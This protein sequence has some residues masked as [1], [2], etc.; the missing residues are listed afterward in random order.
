MSLTKPIIISGAGISG[1][2]FAQGLL[3]HK[4]PFKIF[5]RDPA[6]NVRSQGYRV[7]INGYGVNALRAVL[8]PPLFHRLQESCPAT[9]LGPPPKINAVTGQKIELQ[10]GGKPMG[11]G[12]DA[13]GAERLKADR[14]V[15]RSVLMIGLE[16]FIEYGKDFQSYEVTENGVLVRFADGT[17]VEGSL[18]VGADGTKSGVRRQ[19][20]P[21]HNL[22]DTEGR[23]FYGKTFLTPELLETFNE[24]AAKS[25]A[26]VQEILPNGLP[27]SL[28]LE[29]VK[30]KDNEFRKDL[31]ADYVYWVLGSRKDTIDLDDVAIK[32]LTAEEA[33][34]ETLRLTAHWDPS[35]RILFELQEKSQTSILKI[36]TAKPEIP[37]WQTSERV[38]L[39]GDSV[40]AMS[41]TA[42]V[43]AVTALRSAASLAE[44]IGEKGVTKDALRE[45]ED[46]MRKVAGEAITRSQFGGKMI[47]G[48]RSFAELEKSSL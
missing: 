43:G 26:L 10:F 17:S 7:A 8:P 39:I 14:T 34:L 32:S 36:D 24:D 18:L 22:I 46:K 9:T 30:F 4:I 45:Y 27:R 11:P 42:G 20:L 25:F 5:E 16:S 15:L 28:I 35:I 48:M 3:K 40:H 33:A 41:P 38:T 47:F 29:P 1:L 6:L 37:V 19:L 44:V 23:W 2:A 31:P 21:D 12:P 13:E